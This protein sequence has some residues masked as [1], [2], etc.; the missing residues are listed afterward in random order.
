MNE[1]YEFTGETKNVEGRTL[2]RI[3]A[4]ANFAEVKEGE[5]GGWIEKG[6]NLS[7]YGNAWVSG[8]A[9][10]YCSARVSGDAMVKTSKDYLCIGPIGDNRFI[11]AFKTKDSF[12][13]SAGCF[14]GT[15]EEFKE[16]V[17]KKYG[18]D[19]EYHLAL[20]L[21]QKRMKGGAE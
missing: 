21:I 10:V 19:S 13:I 16:A 2:K 11:T 14:L 20:N 15:A 9:S 12:K 6:K 7:V 3:R 5:L 18:K 1:K 17:E 8:D 4:K